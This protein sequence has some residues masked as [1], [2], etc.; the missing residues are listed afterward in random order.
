MENSKNYESDERPKNIINMDLQKIY[1]KI[2]GRDFVSYKF[3]KIILGTKRLISNNLNYNDFSKEYDDITKMSSFK[4][5][6]INVFP[7]SKNSELISLGKVRYLYDSTRKRVQSSILPKSNQKTIDKTKNHNLFLKSNSINYNSKY[8]NR[9]RLNQAKNKEKNKLDKFQLDYNSNSSKKLSK[10]KLLGS[11][12][13]K[14]STNNIKNDQ[15]ILSNDNSSFGYASNYSNKTNRIYSSS[16]RNNLK[17]QH[18]GKK[19]LIRD[20]F[21]K[22]LK[23]QKYILKNRIL[24]RDTLL[25]EKSYLD[26]EYNEEKIF[27]KVEHY[28][29]FIK[30]KIE[31]IKLNKLKLNNQTRFEKIYE[32]SKFNNPK[33]VLKPIIIEFTKIN[34]FQNK[35]LDN[36]EQKQIF[37]IPFEFIPLF[38][39]Y[40]FSK[41]KEILSCI[42]HLN[43][44]FSKFEVNY[45]N[46][47]YLLKRSSEFNDSLKPSQ[48]Q[49]QR[50]ISKK[51]YT[52]KIKSLQ[53]LSLN[54]AS[55]TKMAK[56][57]SVSNPK[58]SVKIIDIY[59]D[60][61]TFKPMNNNYETKFIGRFKSKSI[62]NDDNYKPKKLYF[63]NKNT[64]EYI[65]LTPNY[66][67]LVNI[68]TPEISFYINDFTIN[69]NADIELLFFLLENKFENWD[70]YIIEYLFSF[71]KFSL[72]INNFLS[73]YKI[74]KYNLKN[75]FN[76]K[77]KIINLSEEKKLKYSKKN[78]K[79]EYIFTDENKI[80]YIKIFHYY[81]LLVF[82]KKI[83]KKYQFCF[84]MNSIQM[85]SFYFSVKK[86]GIKHLIEKLLFFDRDNMKIKLN[87]NYLDNF[88]KEDFNNLEN[89]I[90]KSSNNPKENNKENKYNFNLND[91]KLCLI[92]PNIES[93]KFKNNLISNSKGDCF[94]S[95]S[96]PEVKERLDIK[97]LEKI[98][99]TNDLFQWPNII[100]MINIKKKQ[101]NNNN[102]NC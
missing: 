41:L 31:D 22:M 87:Y 97:I 52:S 79:F 71:L 68:K 25:N 39:I 4:Y 40:N 51:T 94:E 53:S 102:K 2:L 98:L 24:L 91:T 95:N 84:H 21:I 74:N 43:E 27:M 35:P 86:Q 70:F 20:S 19:F 57:I 72:I 13:H 15:H 38:Y 65:W 16:F 9:I 63:S 56:R 76:F 89:L 78:N 100:E 47:S 34:S 10:Y 54:K 55:S 75:N 28:N 67:Y 42:F 73:L 85:Y 88:G 30:N 58:E 101:N 64:F 81:K 6:D 83:N 46:F 69:K 1:L 49:I 92:F 32:K 44:D 18:Y 37:E 62:P 59:G 77:N 60:E 61:Y 12:L 3:N 36:Q 93:I 82:N 7:I 14:E 99:K 33:L 80:N 48:A 11:P 23:Y 26:F 66:E 96:I 45:D 90:Q 17:E 8:I 5:P 29:Y 50:N